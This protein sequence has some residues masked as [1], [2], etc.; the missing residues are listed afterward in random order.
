MT[1]LLFVGQLTHRKWIVDLLKAFS[2]LKSKKIRLTIIG[3][4][5]LK[6]I[7]NTYTDNDSRIVHISKV[8]NS[9]LWDFYSA[10]NI[11]ILPTYN[12][13]FGWVLV[14]A[15]S[16]WVP[17]ISTFVEGPVDI[18]DNEIDGLLIHP[19]DVKS[20][21][22]KINLLSHNKILCQKLGENARKKV[23]SKFS[24][25]KVISQFLSIYSVFKY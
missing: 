17:V 5:P 21:A 11:F 4:W 22:S 3:D 20:L 9:E 24:T 8:N 13:S 25:K 2:L 19:G 12:E 1:N 7:V 16:Y 23:I 15:M 18:I 6:S 14:E 10:T